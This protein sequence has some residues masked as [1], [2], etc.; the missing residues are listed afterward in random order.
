MSP[1]EDYQLTIHTHAGSTL[2]GKLSQRVENGGSTLHV[3][4]LDDQGRRDQQVDSS[5]PSHRND[6]LRPA[7]SVRRNHS[8]TMT[9]H[10]RRSLPE[11]RYHQAQ[12]N[13]DET[14]HGSLRGRVLPVVRV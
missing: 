9:I 13:A 4:D 2:T 6:R 12:G 8:M 10:P 5:G 11:T 14:G 1:G 7:G 3:D